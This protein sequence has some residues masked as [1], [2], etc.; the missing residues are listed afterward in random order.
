MTADVDRAQIEASSRVAALNRPEQQQ[1]TVH[2][3]LEGKDEDAKDVDTGADDE[4]SVEDVGTE[5][6]DDE[7]VEDVGTEDV[8]EEKGEGVDSEK[9]TEYE[10]GEEEKEGES[11]EDADDSEGGDEEEEGSDNDVEK[12][13]GDESE[14][15]EHF[16][17]DVEDAVTEDDSEE[18]EEDVNSKNETEDEIE[19]EETES[20]EEEVESEDR[21]IVILNETPEDDTR[22]RRKI[23]TRLM[24]NKDVKGMNLVDES[25]EDEEYAQTSKMECIGIL[26]EAFDIIEKNKSTIETALRSTSTYF[27]ENEAVKSL[28]ERYKKLFREVGDDT[29]GPDA[30]G[31]VDVAL[32]TTDTSRGKV[33]EKSGGSKKKRKRGGDT[34][35]NNLFK[36]LP[37]SQS[38]PESDNEENNKS[39]KGRRN[40]EKNMSSKAAPAKGKVRMSLNQAMAELVRKKAEKMAIQEK[41][42]AAPKKV[43]K[44]VN[45]EK[46]GA[47]AMK[48]VKS[49]IVHYMEPT[50][51]VQS[52]NLASDWLILTHKNSTVESRV[53]KFNQILCNVIGM[54]NEEGMKLI[55]LKLVPVMDERHYYMLVFDL[56]CLDITVIDNKEGDFICK[57]GNIK[58]EDKGKTAK[59]V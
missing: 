45:Q 31:P 49:T 13:E 34:D 58:L 54:G 11:D 21:E 36:L 30:T 35:T 14:R 19:E 2:S 10:T 37:D 16:E 25:D 9:E 28:A 6:D 52:M 1:K 59:M 3:E 46:V 41:V 47:N 29:T 43:D 23:M 39:E 5:D 22:S 17:H 7:N 33:A 27:P 56:A 26:E 20:E 15:N 4:E 51:G 8:S 50:E 18:K 32:E 44:L 40:K 42:E 38:T 53:K 55:D 12:D 48:A 57:D 24:R